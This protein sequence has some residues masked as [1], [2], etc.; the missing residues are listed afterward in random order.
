MKLEFLHDISDGGRFREIE[1]DELIRLFD[2]G[3][4]EAEQLRIQI[5]QVIIE[6]GE[7]LKFSELPFIDAINCNLT[8]RIA[9]EIIGII[10]EDY[11]NFYCDLPKVE[12]QKMLALI[13]PFTEKNSRGYQWLYD[14][15]NPIDFL[16][17]PGGSW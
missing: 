16:F 11:V 14:I 8:M 1:T 7:P 13:Q 9:E 5:Q 15:D 6:K 4:V 3:K 10:T 17:A 2:F 12:Y